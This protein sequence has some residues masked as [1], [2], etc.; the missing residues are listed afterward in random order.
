MGI[1]R[2]LSW[3]LEGCAGEI[4]SMRRESVGEKGP[5]F[6]LAPL[7]STSLLLI[8]KIEAKEGGV[9]ANG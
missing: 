2:K 6:S 9:E 8:L 4:R 5:R 7:G 3:V 1:Y